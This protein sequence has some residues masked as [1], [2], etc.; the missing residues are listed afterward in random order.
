MSTATKIQCPHCG[1]D[2][3]VNN[4]L[5]HQLEEQYK[6]KYTAELSA[7]KKKYELEKNKLDE[8]RLMLEEQRAEQ[9]RVVDE[10]V[11]K[12]M[13]EQRVKLEKELSAKITEEQ[14]QEI[15]EYKKELNDKSEKLKELMKTKA[16]NERL[17]REKNELRQQLE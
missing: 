15:A 12:R 10:Q 2:I 9:Q 1:G 6:K 14:S 13:N 3:D 8:Q 17:V 5:S 16:E 7:E 11:A 4:V